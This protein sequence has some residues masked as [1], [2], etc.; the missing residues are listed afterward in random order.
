MKILVLEDEK[1]AAQNIIG[2]L[3]NYFD[4]ESSIQW[5]QSIE[6]GLNYLNK[7]GD[8]DLILSDIELLDGQAFNLYDQYE[9]ACPIIFTTAYDQFLLKAFQTNGIAYLLKPFSADELINALDKYLKLFK[10][11]KAPLLNS[12]MVNEFKEAFT[13]SQKKYKKRFTIKKTSGIY[14]LE[15]KDIVYFLAENDLIFAVDRQAKKH[16]LNNSLNEI[17]ELLDPSEFF[18]IN[19]SEIVNIEY[20][21]KMEN[22]FGNRLSIS[23]TNIKDSLKTSGPKTA[24]FRK[25]V[26][27]N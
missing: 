7:H 2:I 3:T 24:S 9:V 10:T 27:G 26:D 4:N 22:Y 15:T 25:W 5:V 12:A 16:V 23:L 11:Q 19:R 13:S 18:R 20:I 6:H 14:L 17:E 8:P 21:E 1:I